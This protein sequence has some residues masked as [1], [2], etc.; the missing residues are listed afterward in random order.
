MPEVPRAVQRAEPA[1]GARAVR[2]DRAE[3]GVVQPIGHRVVERIEQHRVGDLL[4]ADLLR[5]VRVVKRE[6]RRD[7]LLGHH[8]GLAQLDH[9]VAHHRERERSVTPCHVTPSVARLGRPRSVRR[10]RPPEPAGRFAPRKAAAAAVRAAAASEMPR[11]P[12]DSPRERNFSGLG[13]SD[14]GRALCGTRDAR[15]GGPPSRVAQWH[16]VARRHRSRRKTSGQREKKQ[17]RAERRRSGFAARG[18]LRRWRAT[19]CVTRGCFFLFGNRRRRGNARAFRRVRL[20]MK[21]ETT[22]HYRRDRYVRSVFVALVPP[23]PGVGF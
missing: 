7:H 17:H 21:H 3:R 14:R 6:G 1:R 8:A 22:I 11:A 20:T 23:E 16:R 19:A 5:L 12:R 10:T 4:D 15:S 2:V 9:G 13:V 18:P